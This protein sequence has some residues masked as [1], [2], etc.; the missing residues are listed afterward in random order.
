ML[1]FIG[2]MKLFAKQFSLVDRDTL[3][4][5]TADHETGGMSVSSL[6]S[7]LASEDG[8]FNTA[9]GNVFY[10]NWSTTGHTAVNVPITSQGPTSEKLSGIHDNT[11]VHSVMSGALSGN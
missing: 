7:G 10:V 2:R 3:I 8:P 4:I 6:S 5:V 11:F 9:D 1:V